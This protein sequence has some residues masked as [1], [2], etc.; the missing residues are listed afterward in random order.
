MVTVTPITALTHLGN[1]GLKRFLREELALLD[2]LVILG[3]ALLELLFPEA[4]GHCAV[5][6]IGD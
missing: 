1:P 3:R 4:F 2:L 6:V 5:A